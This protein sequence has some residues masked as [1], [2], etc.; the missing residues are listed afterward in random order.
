[1]NI[2]L[3]CI[4]SVNK[5][6][7]LG[8]FEDCQKLQ[9]LYLRKNNIKDINELGYLQVINFIWLSKSPL[10]WK[11]NIYNINLLILSFFEQQI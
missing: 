11:K 10:L 1:M 8:D 5:I 7:G 2:F 4:F 3:F 6:S 9:E